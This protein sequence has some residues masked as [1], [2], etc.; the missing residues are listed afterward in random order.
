MPCVALL[1]ARNWADVV[2]SASLRG[3]ENQI[4]AGLPIEE[5]NALSPHMRVVRLQLRETVLKPGDAVTDVFFPLTTMFS[6]VTVLKDGSRVEAAT[7]GNEGM[8]GLPFSIPGLPSP[9]LML[10]QIPGEAIRINAGE[11]RAWLNLSPIGRE[12]LD[13]HSQTLL[14]TTAQTAACN[15]LHNVEHRCARWLLMMHDRARSDTFPMTQDLLATMLGVRR[16]SVNVAAL[17]LQQLGLISYHHGQM[18][19]VDR[20]GLEG[21]S[22]ECY[23]VVKSH[24]ALMAKRRLRT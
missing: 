5:R 13:R 14:V 10:V 20:A 3:G 23:E 19:I 6:I 4:L 11:F 2:Q 22:C 16:A 15:R 18:E 9:V 1:A 7:I 17:S 24:Q 8:T 12:L 21:A